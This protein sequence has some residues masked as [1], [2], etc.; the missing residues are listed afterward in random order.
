MRPDSLEARTSGSFHPG[1][2]AQIRAADALKR[3]LNE[4]GAEPGSLLMH[5]QHVWASATY[6]GV[7]HRLVYLF[8]GQEAVEHGLALIGEIPEHKFSIPHQLVADAD[9]INIDHCLTEPP[10]LE[11]TLELLLLDE[12]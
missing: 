9:V 10:R 4:L 2:A 8:L 3:E 6:A 1:I 7:R 5:E 11:L 12:G